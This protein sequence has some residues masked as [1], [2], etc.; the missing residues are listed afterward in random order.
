MARKRKF[1]AAVITACIISLLTPQAVFAA[2]LT[3]TGLETTPYEDM[4]I[5]PED[6]SIPKGMVTIQAILQFAQAP[7]I[8]VELHPTFDG[9]TVHFYRLTVENNFITTD[10]IAS[11]EYRA[12]AMLD[13]ED[14]GEFRVVS[15]T[16]YIHVE[17]GRNETVAVLEGTQRFCNDYMWLPD[18]SDENGNYLSGHVT[19]DQIE[20]LY[21]Y[22][23]SGDGPEPVGEELAYMQEEQQGP[24]EP[25]TIPQ[26]V[27]VT[28]PETKDD[29]GIRIMPVLPVIVI[30]VVVAAVIVVLVIRRKR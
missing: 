10:M 24:T 18:V 19:D 28:E 21:E 29:E 5:V 22:M 13:L 9:G 26:Y 23:A 30:I 6:D 15:P 12:V 17:Y 1:I 11:G 4:D 20:A 2:P 16:H 27:E 25:E 8:L 14:Y 3:D 7:D